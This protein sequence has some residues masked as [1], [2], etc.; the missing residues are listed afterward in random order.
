[1]VFTGE[2]ILEIINTGRKLCDDKPHVLL[3]DVR[4]LAELT[5]EARKVGASKENTKNLVAHAMVVK[6]LGT[7]MGANVFLAINKPHYPLRVFNDEA[8]AV[9]WLLEKMKG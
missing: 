7:R 3:T 9:K 6:W 8:K 4:V 5:P 2:K 1:M